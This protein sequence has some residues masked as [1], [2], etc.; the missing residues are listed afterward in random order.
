MYRAESHFMCGDKIKVGK[1]VGE[2]PAYSVVEIVIK[3]YLKH[4]AVDQLSPFR[5]AGQNS[6]TKFRHIAA[7]FLAK[8]RLGQV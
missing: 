2:S 4:L 1:P 7:I 3:N 8:F 6:L 5:L